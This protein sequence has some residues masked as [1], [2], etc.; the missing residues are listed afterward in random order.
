M[1]PATISTHKMLIVIAIIFTALRLS[2][3]RTQTIERHSP[4]STKT[5]FAADQ[6]PCIPSGKVNLNKIG[7]K[8]ANGK[9]LMINAATLNF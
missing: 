3:F 9:T 4:K 5:I 7:I 2:L 6:M 1:K 8:V